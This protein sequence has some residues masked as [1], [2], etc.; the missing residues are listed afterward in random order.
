MESGKFEKADTEEYKAMVKADL[1]EK[2]NRR[3][4]QCHK[5]NGGGA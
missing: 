1:I 5:E 4:C 3:V 2:W